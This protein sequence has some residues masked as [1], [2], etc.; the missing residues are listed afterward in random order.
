VAVAAEAAS[1]VQAL[2][3]VSIM[4]EPMRVGASAQPP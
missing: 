4:A 2:I 3:M 1:T